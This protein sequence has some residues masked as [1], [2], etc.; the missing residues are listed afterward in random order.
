VYTTRI[1]SDQMSPAEPA[2][3]TWTDTSFHGTLPA[4]TIPGQY[5]VTVISGGVPSVSK[6]IRIEPESPPENPDADSD[7]FGALADCDDADPLVWSRPGEVRN[8]LLTHDPAAEATTLRWQAPVLLGA[9]SVA[10][11]T[12]V[13]G[14]PANFV[15]DTLCVESDDGTDTEAATS[16]AP[17]PGAAHFYLVRAQNACPDG[18]GPLGRRSDGATRV[19]RTCP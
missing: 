16:S 17:P 6:I 4:G 5:R 8:L 15:A 13:S 18:E 14:D 19:G 11:D 9:V 12:L 7:G 3:G 1:E 2:R 10:Y